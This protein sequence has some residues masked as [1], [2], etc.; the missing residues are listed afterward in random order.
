MHSF[1][2]YN[3]VFR[4]ANG[5]LARYHTQVA[6]SCDGGTAAMTREFSNIQFP[7]VIRVERD[8]DV[9]SQSEIQSYL[10]LVTAGVPRD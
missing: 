5:L 6:V 7:T 10:H 3:T 4:M 2:H 1:T 8:S 9:S